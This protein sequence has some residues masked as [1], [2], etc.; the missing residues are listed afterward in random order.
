MVLCEDRLKGFGTFKGAKDVL[1]SEVVGM[2]KELLQL[3]ERVEDL[4]GEIDDWER[5]G[6]K[7]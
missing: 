6:Y 5:C 3:R 7:K 4:E 2:S 1:L